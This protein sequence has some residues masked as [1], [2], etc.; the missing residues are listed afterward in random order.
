MA[1][2]LANFASVIKLY[3]P[4]K[5]PVQLYTLV[6]HTVQLWQPEAER[7]GINLQVGS[8]PLAPQPI[9]ADA[10]QLEQVLTNI[11]KNAMEAAGA[12]GSIV[13]EVDSLG[14]KLT[15]ADNGSGLTP[16]AALNIFQRPFFST[17]ERGQGIGLMIIREILQNHEAR[18]ALGTHPDG[19]TRF[20]ISFD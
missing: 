8:A 6:Q 4:Q 14:K 18:Y 13:A 15:I 17:K 3:A 5:Q 20:E 1:T 12:G 2:F 9:Q 19:W 11:L 7:R 10:V 16:D